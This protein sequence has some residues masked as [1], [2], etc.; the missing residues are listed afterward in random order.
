MKIFVSGQIH[1]IENVRK[2]Q[3]VL[4]ESG[5]TI[6]HDWTRNESGDKILQTSEDKLRDIAE[7][8]KRANL[9]IQGV[10]DCDVYIICTSNEK[11]GKGM[12]V[13]LGAALALSQSIGRPQ[14]FL[15]GKMNHISVFYLH[16]NLTRLS[17]VQEVIEELA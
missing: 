6:T 9:D 7:T 13:E 1:D 15:I 16:P 14:V 4:T 3:K 8:G 11:P 12:Y 5:H 2:T 10:L 17:N